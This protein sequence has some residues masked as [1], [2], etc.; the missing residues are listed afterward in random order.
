[1]SRR[2]TR[3]ISLLAASA[4]LLPAAASPHEED[5]QKFLE[6]ALAG[7][8]NFHAVIVQKRISPGM[9]ELLVKIQVVPGKGM[10]TTILQPLSMQG[11][12]VT[13]DGEESKVYNPDRDEILVQ[14]SPNKFLPPVSTRARLIRANY[15][16]S[17]GRHRRLA[18]RPCHEVVLNPKDERMPQRRLTIE[19][20]KRLIMRYEITPPGGESEM[21]TDVASVVFDEREANESFGLPKSAEGMRVRRIPGPTVVSDPIKVK[22]ELGFSLKTPGKLPFGFQVHAVHVVGR[23]G[24]KALA[25]RTGDGMSFVTIY[26]RKG[27]SRFDR[28]SHESGVSVEKDKV[29]FTAVTMAGDPIP[30]AVLAGLAE[31]VAGSLS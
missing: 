29:R 27:D 24:E 30:R 5:A 16:V 11:I 2:L 14:P 20:S 19:D 18:G 25:I 26:V 7:Q 23:P 21:F 12:V 6:L 17:Y 31:A 15:S 1:M 8:R 9:P 3:A 4:G 22:A 28:G 13:D 10:K